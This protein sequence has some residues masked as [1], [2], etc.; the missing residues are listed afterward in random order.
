MKTNFTGIGTATRTM[1][2]G[3]PRKIVKTVVGCRTMAFIIDCKAEKVIVTVELEEKIVHNKIVSQEAIGIVD[4][5]ESVGV[6]VA[7]R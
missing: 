6:L 2:D 3:E 1:D 4:C 7:R 5:P